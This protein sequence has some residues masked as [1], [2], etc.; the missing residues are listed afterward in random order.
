MR[1]VIW[2]D[3]ALADLS[4]IRDWLVREAGPRTALNMLRLVRTQTAPLTSFPAVGASLAHQRRKLRV[5]R[6]PYV[7]LYE[8]HASEV[9]IL[10]V[11][12][13]RQN[14]RPSE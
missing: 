11:H 14:W 8:I 1:R 12:Y 2:S 13:V 5:R 7:L 9:H 4:N 10:R 6:T 3:P